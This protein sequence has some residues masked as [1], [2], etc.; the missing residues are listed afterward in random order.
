MLT[1]HGNVTWNASVHHHFVD[2]YLIYC[3][4][5][6]EFAS[7]TFCFELASLYSLFF[8]SDDRV[9][10]FFHAGRPK[11]GVES[12]PQI[13]CMNC[14]RTLARCQCSPLHAAALRL[15]LPLSSAHLFPSDGRQPTILCTSCHDVAKHLAANASTCCDSCERKTDSFFSVPISEYINMNSDAKKRAFEDLVASG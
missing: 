4:S 8:A 15:P 14:T 2:I 9:S 5:M 11:A 3:L 13:T 7:F 6:R 1:C 10:S 12:P